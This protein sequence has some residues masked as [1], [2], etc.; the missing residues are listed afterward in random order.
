MD[1]PP[2]QQRN[3]TLHHSSAQARQPWAAALGCTCVCVKACMVLWWCW[4][5]KRKQLHVNHHHKHYLASDSVQLLPFP[6]STRTV[7]CGWH[8][9]SSKPKPWLR[10]F[11]TNFR[12][13]LYV[14]DDLEHAQARRFLIYH[15]RG[16]HTQTCNKRVYEHWT[17]CAR[18]EQAFSL[19]RAM[20]APYKSSDFLVGRLASF[21]G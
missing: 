17:E 20:R 16:N 13:E 2:R 6:W 3:A 14:S 7:D 1:V 21:S 12:S 4:W 5:F 19:M 11:T 9:L 15:K 10:Y 18:R 8:S